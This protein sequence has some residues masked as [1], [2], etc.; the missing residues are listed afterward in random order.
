MRTFLEDMVQV[1]SPFHRVLS[2]TFHSDDT[3]SKLAPSME[4]LRRPALA[5]V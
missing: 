1:A 3:A 5:V 2:L 4:G